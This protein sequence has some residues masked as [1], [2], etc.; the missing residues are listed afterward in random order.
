MGKKCGWP[1]DAAQT[2]GDEGSEKKCHAGAEG[3]RGEFLSVEASV[4]T[5]CVSCLLLARILN[6]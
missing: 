1:R 3:A 6:S 5:N 2:E 4:K